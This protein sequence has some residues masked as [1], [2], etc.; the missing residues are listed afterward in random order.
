MHET[1][2]LTEI[3]DCFYIKK[4]LLLKAVLIKIKRM[5]KFK[6]MQGL[7]ND[8]VIIFLDKNF[9]SEKEIRFVCDRKVGIGCDLLVIL[10]KNNDGISDYI[11]SFFNADGSEAEI[12][13]NALRC[14]GKL[15]YKNESKKNCLVETKSGL[16]DVEYIDTNNISV[17][18]GTPKFGWKDIPLNQNLDCSNLGIKLNYLKGGFALNIGNPHLIFF[19]D[20]L[21][22]KELVKDSQIITNGPIFPNGVNISAVKIESRGELSV[23]TFE[24]GVG[25]TNA[26]GTGASAS[27]VAANKMNYVDD[28]TLIK[29]IGG[30]L[31]VEISNDNHIFITGGAR[32]V[33][34]GM[35]DLSQNE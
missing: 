6:K 9:L 22:K 19:V 21:L 34:E 2:G 7:G 29:M 31:H 10:R 14:I 1:R 4:Q 18:L 32:D 20:K 35:I 13:G 11:A 5:M 26:C 24:R 16:V 25:L 30:K 15:H 3:I 17:D 8:F 23:L 33:F 27:F 28:T 12:C